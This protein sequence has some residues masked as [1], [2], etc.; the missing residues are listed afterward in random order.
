M[1]AFLEPPEGRKIRRAIFKLHVRK[2]FVNATSKNFPAN[3]LQLCGIQKA[4]HGIP[5]IPES[6]H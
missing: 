6:C 3:Q 5:R 1:A 2:N 4:Q